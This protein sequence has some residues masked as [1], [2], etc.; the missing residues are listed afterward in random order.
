VPVIDSDQTLVTL[1]VTKH[2]QINN[3]VDNPQTELRAR[4]LENEQ[5]AC[6]VLLT[7][8]D[9]SFRY[10]EADL[11]EASDNTIALP[12]HWA[13][14]GRQGGVWVT[15]QSGPYRVEW[16]RLGDVL[17]MI[18]RD[19][20]AVGPPQFYS[21]QGLRNLRLYPRPNDIDLHLAFK[22][23]AVLCEDSADGEGCL[24]FPEMWRRSV[25]FEMVIEREMQDKGEFDGL[26]IQKAKV[27]EALHNMCCDEQQGLPEDR[28]V[29]HYIGMP[30]AEN[31]W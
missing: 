27:K 8:R 16:R 14:E 21:V 1:V 20:N 24:V 5:D 10:V 17:D 31:P 25:L 2:H 30:D 19:P 29:P 7:Y 15:N 13:N 23:N 12:A 4:I 6:N 11:I 26:V 9:W 3:S 28:R 22:V 18:Q